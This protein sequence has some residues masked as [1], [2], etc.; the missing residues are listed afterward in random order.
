MKR[1]VFKNSNR[2]RPAYLY[3]LFIAFLLSTLLPVVAFFL[4]LQHNI[5]NSL[6]RIVAAVIIAFAIAIVLSLALLRP[7]QRA[8]ARSEIQRRKYANLL[9]TLKD[10]IAIYDLKGNILEVNNYLCV[11]L[12]YSKDEVVGA[13]TIPN[14][15]D[16]ENAKLWQHRIT[17]VIARRELLYETNYVTKDGGAIP[18]EVAA[19]VIDYEGQRAI[20]TAA[21]DISE[22][23][24]TSQEE[25]ERLQ[26]EHEERIQFLLAA[27]HEIKTPLTAIKSSSELLDT[28]LKEVDDYTKR[29]IDNIRRGVDAL[30]RRLDDIFDS[31]KMRSSKIEI[32]KQPASLKEVTAEAIELL[33]GEILKR[34]LNLHAEIPADLPRVLVDRKRFQQIL[35]NIIGNSVKF[36][37]EGGSINLRTSSQDDNFVVIEIQDTGSGI[38]EKEQKHIFEPFYRGETAKRST[39]GLGLGLTI[40]KNLVEL[41]GGKIWIKSHKGAGTSIYFTVPI[42]KPDSNS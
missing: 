35:L 23:K 30:G 41:H 6:N 27:A 29:L 24:R 11:R 7:F 36:T 9:D 10:F 13:V 37:P 32:Y 12:G 22:R 2:E 20:L 15:E 18:V 42:Y 8:L 34:K 40:V 33:S 31:A 1:G 38:S 19:R 21:R 4:L 16:S 25:K 3:Y 14:P 17:E 39:G 26:Q 28:K 5:G